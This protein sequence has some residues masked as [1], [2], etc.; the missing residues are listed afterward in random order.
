MKFDD[1]DRKI[2]AAVSEDGK[3]SA[4]QLAEKVGASAASCWRR[5]KALE[6][7]DVIKGYHADI[8]YAALGY[9]LTAF[10]QVTLNR[11]DKDNNKRFEGAVVNLSEIV[12]CHSVTG[13][14]DYILQVRVPN[15]RDYEELLNDKIFQLP[16]VQQ[17]FSTIALKTV[18]SR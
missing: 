3:Q 13:Q 7:A 10:A 11:H 1:I 6:D 4:Q 8:D 18:K 15:V 12:T 16:G 5:V 9:E 2:I 14:S 17:V